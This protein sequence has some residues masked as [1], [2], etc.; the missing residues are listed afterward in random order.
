M[1]CLYVHALAMKFII[2]PF[3]HVVGDVIGDAGEFASIP[4][5][6]VMK[7]GVPAKV[8]SHSAH[9]PGYSRFEGAKYGREGVVAGVAQAGVWAVGADVIAGG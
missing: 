3:G 6:V 9:V 7:A 8:K 2:P 4:D 5:D 1:P